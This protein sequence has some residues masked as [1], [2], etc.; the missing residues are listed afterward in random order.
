MPQ[1]KKTIVVSIK[2]NICPAGK[3]DGF[4]PATDGSSDRKGVADCMCS[5]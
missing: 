5:P 4:S 1:T 3:I 2:G